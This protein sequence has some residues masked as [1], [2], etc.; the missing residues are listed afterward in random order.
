MLFILVWCYNANC[1]SADEQ[2]RYYK[3]FYCSSIDFKVFDF[4]IAEPQ[5]SHTLRSPLFDVR[6]LQEYILICCQRPQGGLID[7]PET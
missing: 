5:L 6:A 7:K 1:A 2:K 3:P 4:H